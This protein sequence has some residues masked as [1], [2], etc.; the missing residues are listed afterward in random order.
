MCL[1]SFRTR[2]LVREIKQLDTI[3]RPCSQGQTDDEERCWVPDRVTWLSTWQ[4]WYV[5]VYHWFT[6]FR[7]HDYRIP[8]T[9]SRR[10]QNKNIRSTSIS[11]IIDKR[12][13]RNEKNAQTQRD[14][15]TVTDMD[16]VRTDGDDDDETGYSEDD[17]REDEDG[18]VSH[19]KRRQTC[20][21]NLTTGVVKRM[22]SKE[23]GNLTATCQ[24]GAIQ[25]HHSDSQWRYWGCCT[26]LPQV[27]HRPERQDLKVLPGVAK[28]PPDFMKEGN[29]NDTHTHTHT[30][31]HLPLCHGHTLS[32][33]TDI[34]QHIDH[35]LYTYMTSCLA[36]AYRLS[37]LMDR[38]TLFID[39]WLIRLWVD[40]VLFIN[41]RSLSILIDIPSHYR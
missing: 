1:R 28:N 38:P 6:R 25:R 16:E 29:W 2:E 23:D 3:F 27:S 21:F 26:A 12:N 11:S 13:S 30:Y 20:S 24:V 5:G 37:I 35:G 19:S 39:S 22:E 40:N 32:I 33:V 15:N 18:S 41:T 8:K 14:R 34:H 7:T 36:Q 4:R 17:H 10:I 9:L 31:T